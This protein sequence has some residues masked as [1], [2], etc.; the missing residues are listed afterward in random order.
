[1]RTRG[2][3]EI[4]DE[5]KF[6]NATL[7]C[8]NK[9]R[10]AVEKTPVCSGIPKVAVYFDAEHFGQALCDVWMNKGGSDQA[11]HGKPSQTWLL[12]TE[13]HAMAFKLMPTTESAIKIEWYDP[14]YTTIVHRL[15]VSNE[16]IFQQL[17]LN[18]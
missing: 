10:S 9:N 16:E 8:S 17:T 3:R 4:P 2:F 11:S 12:N 14:N 5:V 18:Q 7:Q 13:N 15:I 6:P 1:M